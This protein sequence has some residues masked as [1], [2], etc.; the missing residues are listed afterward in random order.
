MCWSRKTQ[1]RLKVTLWHKHNHGI[2]FIVPHTYGL[3]IIS[4]L[5][6]KKFNFF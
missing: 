5:D 4:E 1:S 6:T 3:Q 2:T